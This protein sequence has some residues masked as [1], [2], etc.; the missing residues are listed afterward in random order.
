MFFCL[1]YC[2]IIYI[3]YIKLFLYVWTKLLSK[4]DELDVEIIEF[5]SCW[6]LQSGFIP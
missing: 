3:L 1:V 4:T 6:F 2:Y 5:L